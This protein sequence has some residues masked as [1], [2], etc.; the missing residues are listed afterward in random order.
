MISLS[1]KIKS[2]GIK[3]VYFTKE[4]KRVYP[5]NNLAANVIGFVGLDNSG[6]DGVEYKFNNILSGKDEVV[7]DEISREIYQKKNLT[8]TIDRYIQHV[9]ED[10]LSKAMLL[11]RA[12][13]GSVVILE[14]D[15]GR[16]L[17]IA[18]YPSFDPNS[19]NNYN[20]G[21]TFQFQYC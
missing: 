15:T 4:Y 11:H 3:G 2:L 19:F 1:A 14:V 6:L 10:E 16:V 9:A 5:Y 13:Q 12:T 8:L 20:S 17:A 7:K 18:K 21:S